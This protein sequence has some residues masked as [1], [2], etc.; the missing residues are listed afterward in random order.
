LPKPKAKPKNAGSPRPKPK[1]SWFRRLLAWTAITVLC[2]SAL[3]M[4]VA[5]G[6]WFWI[7]QDLPRIDRLADYAPPAVTQVFA[8]DGSLM[9]EYSRQ[10]RYVI[11]LNQ[12]PPH[13]VMAF[14]SA[15]DGEFFHHKGVDLMGIVRA[16]I[17]NLKA[18]RVVQGG[19]T[20]TQ[21]VAKALLL[22]PQRTYIRKIKEWI[23]AYRMESYLTK[24]E[25]LFLYLNQIYLGHG[26]YGIQ[27]AAQVY[28]GKP[29]KELTI[30]EAALLAGLLRAPS[31]YSPIRHP[32]RART[33]QVYVIGRMVA[34]GHISQAQADQALNQ[35]MDIRSHRPATVDADYY[36]EYV[37]QWLEERYGP[38]MLY[39]GG[40]TVTTAC[41]PRLTKAGYAAIGQGLSELTKRQGFRGPLSTVPPAQL[42]SI[43]E[44]PV[45]AVGLEKGQAMEAVVVGR[46]ADT[47]PV[48]RMGAGRGIIPAAS[49]EWLRRRRGGKPVLKPGDTV[50]VKLVQYRASTRTWQADLVQEPKAQA[51]LLC[52]EAGSGRVRVLIGGRDFDKSQ[53][54]RAIQ[55]HRQP[56]SAFKPFIFSAA[57]DYSGHKFTPVSV[58]L[59]A[60]VVYDDPSRPGDKWKPKNYENQFYGPTTFREALEHSRNVVTV[61][62]LAELG[63]NYAINYARRFGIKSQLTPNLSL[64]LGTSGLSLLELTRA[65][66][67]FVNQGKLV[68]PVMIEEVRDREGKEIYQSRPHFTQAISPQ[69]AFI[70]THL[71][72]GVVE[73]G[74]GR[75]M[76]ALGRPVAGKTGT[77]NDLRDAWFLGFTP[78]LVCG[79]WVG[80]DDNLPLGRKETGARAAGPIWLEFMKDA[81]AND[82][83][84]DF[85]VPPG[86]VFARIDPKTGRAMRAGAAGGFFEAFR[87]GQ[88]PLPASS[89]AAQPQPG[90]A[91]DFMQAE[92]FAPGQPMPR[93]ARP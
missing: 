8:A 67:V 65:Y 52:L 15:E 62:I 2:L 53:F 68:D 55:A 35:H 81:L 47:S 43:A 63:L 71:L 31:R 6:G 46:T 61:K 26:A 10:R 57:L 33:R 79:V 18:G 36:S 34:D 49:L 32:R 90:A 30:A 12:L 1:K 58:I 82:P 78:R 70:V 75:K 16:A 86:V 23:L 5:V 54:N 83:P 45:S 27:A 4:A 41:D 44:R 40:L 91:E 84:Q 22:S 69:T 7:S 72:R 60:P 21:Q 14:V 93:Q 87:E 17:K 92:T 66:S 85:Q 48:V 25:I 19:S 11:P 29:A 51:A 42:K 50:Y 3:G 13:V 20:I 39:E 76:K 56:G 59:D 37:R 88:E 38:T 28:F 64:A 73:N 77:T 9:A 24:Q 74:T 80:Q 89:G